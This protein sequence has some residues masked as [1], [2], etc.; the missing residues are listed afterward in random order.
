VRYVTNLKENNKSEAMSFALIILLEM[1]NFNSKDEY[2][3][4]AYAVACR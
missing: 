3:Q 2:I 1:Q 4:D